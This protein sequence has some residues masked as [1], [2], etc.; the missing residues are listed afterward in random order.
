MTKK[1]ALL[2]ILVLTLLSFGSCKGE[3]EGKGFYVIESEDNQNSV[4]T[5]ACTYRNSYNK[6]T[7]TLTFAQIDEDGKE[8]ELNTLCQEEETPVYSTREFNLKDEDEDDF[9]QYVETDDVADNFI[10]EDAEDV[11]NDEDDMFGDV[12]E[13]EYS[14]FADED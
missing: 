6:K 10:I 9:E 3:G 14:D 11:D 13:D 12:Y 8:I 2:L 1:L 7:R 5:Y 4:M